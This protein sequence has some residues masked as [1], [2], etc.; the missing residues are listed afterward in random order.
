MFGYVI[1][2]II[3]LL[4]YSTYQPLR[5]ARLTITQSAF[6]LVL[7]FLGFALI[8][9]L[10]FNK[11]EAQIQYSSYRRV[12]HQF[13]STLTQQS[14][15]AVI[16]YAIDIYLFNIH[17]IVNQFKVFQKIPTFGAL[18]F[19]LLF[20]AYL[21]VVWNYAYGPYLKIYKTGITK[22]E[23]IFSNISFS[24][25]ILLPWFIISV[26]AD[27]IHFLPF[28]ALKRFLFSA[29]GQVAYFVCFLLVVAIIGPAFIQK[30]WQCRPLDNRIIRLRIEF[31]CKKA[32]MGFKDVLIWPLFG[33]KMIT[34]GVMGLIRQFRYIL[35]T[36]ALI[37]LLNPI[38][39]DAVIAHEIGHIK[40]KHLLFYLCFFIGYI[41]IAFSLM[42]LV[43]YLLIY[44]GAVYGFISNDPEIDS[45]FVSLCFSFSTILIFLIYFR[46]IFGFFM[47]NFERQADIFAFTTIGSPQPLISTFE[48]ISLSSGQSPGKPNWHHFSIQERISYL[49][50]CAADRKWI[51]RHNSKIKKGFLIYLIAM[52]ALGWMG[53][54]LHYGEAREGIQT[55]LVKKII[56]ERIKADPTNPDLNQFIGDV[57]YSEKDY[58]NAISSYQMA[59]TYHQN[60][61]HAL[62]NLA[63]LFATCDDPQYR[64]PQKALEL[65]RYAASLSEEPYILDTLAEAYF[66][67]G[68]WTSAVQS[69]EKAL[70]SAT[71][72]KSYYLDQLEKFKKSAR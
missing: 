10:L 46:Y 3:A 65:A 53:L 27:L 24:V 22:K 51:D 37:D 59:L 54:T 2:Y 25:P 67:N 45:V 38:E 36:P 4:I 5:D 20:M 21:T 71:Q 57:Y 49:I 18:F 6:L 50:K 43:L 13:H 68:D 66:V 60:H 41:V 64:Q 11:I 8:T 52:V 12:D 63:W 23:Y 61:I 7:F 55:N 48:K 17:S 26:T 32:K 35:V 42:D 34:A 16:L 29:E 33:G 19:L 58:G 9:R 56:L 62:N 1:Y 47:R 31:M 40:Q 72:N 30:F 14:I 70:S 69:S 39:I 28:E 15:L 44:L